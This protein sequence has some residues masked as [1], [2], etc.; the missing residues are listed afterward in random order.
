MG[1]NCNIATLIWVKLKEECAADSDHQKQKVVER[2]GIW[3]KRPKVGMVRD[4]DLYT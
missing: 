1:A 4:S 3:Q 2:V